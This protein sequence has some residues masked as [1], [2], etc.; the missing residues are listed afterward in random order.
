MIKYW[1]ENIIYFYSLMIFFEFLNLCYA[2]LYK[3]I[4]SG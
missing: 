3:K 2:I 1:L 4:N